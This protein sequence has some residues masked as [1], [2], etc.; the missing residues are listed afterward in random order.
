VVQGRSDWPVPGLCSIVYYTQLWRGLTCKLELLLR[1]W[2][3]LKGGRQRWGLNQQ[4]LRATAG[5][6]QLHVQCAI[7]LAI[8]RRTAST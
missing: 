8:R 1:C 2:C 3:L 5:A 4:Q 6:A 7:G